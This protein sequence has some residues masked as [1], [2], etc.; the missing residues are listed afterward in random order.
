MSAWSGPRMR[1]TSRQI[2][3]RF[4]ICRIA[5]G[6]SRPRTTD[7][8]GAELPSADGGDSLLPWRRG[9][10]KAD[11]VSQELIGSIRAGRE[12]PPQSEAEI[13]PAPFA[14]LT[15]HQRAQLFPGIV[16]ERVHQD[17]KSTRLNSSHRC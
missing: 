3:A 11:Q 8:E 1:R 4:Q 7:S 15:L 14:Q 17:R 6:G 13:D 2:Y 10:W 16:L 5:V 9:P 12:L